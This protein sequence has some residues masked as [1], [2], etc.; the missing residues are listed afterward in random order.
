MYNSEVNRNA[1]SRILWAKVS[2]DAPTLSNEGCVQSSGGPEWEET[3]SEEDIV[4]T[5]PHALMAFGKG[6]ISCGVLE[7]AERHRQPERM[8]PC[9]LWDR[10]RE[11]ELPSLLVKRWLSRE[12]VAPPS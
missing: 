3:I 6:A 9:L 10:F 12:S 1:R 7:L 2:G 8:Q 11:Q 4:G 5:K